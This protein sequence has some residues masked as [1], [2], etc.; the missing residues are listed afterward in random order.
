M[1]TWDLTK[2]LETRTKSAIAEVC[3][4]VLLENIPEITDLLNATGIKTKAKSGHRAAKP[5]AVNALM[6]SKADNVATV[7]SDS[8]FVKDAS[9]KV[10]IESIIAAPVLTQ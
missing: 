1:L 5:K 4:D 3:S 6:P 9:K 10:A 2:P 7:T 8:L